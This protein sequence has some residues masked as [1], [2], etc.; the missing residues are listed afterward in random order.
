MSSENERTQTVANS[1]KSLT[2]CSIIIWI[3][4]LSKH[5]NLGVHILNNN[6]A[7]LDSMGLTWKR[8]Y[9]ISQ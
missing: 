4:F 1:P 7:A 9:Q 5:V 6:V 3:T 2:D 8:I